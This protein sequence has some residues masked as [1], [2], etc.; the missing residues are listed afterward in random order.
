VAW[1][2]EATHLVRGQATRDDAALVH[3]L[4]AGALRLADNGVHAGE[5]GR[6]YHLMPAAA[7][8][9]SAVARDVAARGLDRAACLAVGNSRED[10]GMGEAVGTMAL[11][12]NG[13]RAEPELVAAARWVTGATYGAGVLEAVRAWL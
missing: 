12:A 10:L 4:S 3:E 5:G 13:A 7:G 2:R 11:V 9:G 8:K 1:P 6:V